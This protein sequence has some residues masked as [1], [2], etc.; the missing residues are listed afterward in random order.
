MIDGAELIDELVGLLQTVPDLLAA[1][2]DD[3]DRIY[4]YHDSYPEHIDIEQAR[5]LMPVPSVMVSYRGM[6]PRGGDLDP[7]DH[8]I[9]LDLRI[10]K[11]TPPAEGEEPDPGETTARGYY[12]M[13]RALIK[14]KP[15][16]WDVALLNGSV[17]ES[18]Y[19]AAVQSIQRQSDREGIDYFEVLM[20]FRE[21]GDD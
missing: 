17:L 1:V 15:A 18:C 12:R 11:E 14:G 6:Q 7:W 21:I 8:V 13:I 5:R 16:G 9:E 3:E 4:A 20:S 2:G 19:P 10:G